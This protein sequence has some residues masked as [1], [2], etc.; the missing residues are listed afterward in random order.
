[1]KNKVFKR[2]SPAGILLA[3][4]CLLLIGA[5]V[6]TAT[7]QTLSA[8]NISAL[9][10]KP[11]SF[12][13][14][15]RPIAEVLELLS[16]QTDL[17]FAY[18]VS[19]GKEKLLVNIDVTHEKLSS[20]IRKILNPHQLDYSIIDGVA[21]VHNLKTTSQEKSEDINSVITGKVFDYKTKETLPG[22]IVSLEG[23]TQKLSTNNKGEFNFA[24]NLKAPYRLTVSYMGYKTTTVV[25]NN[26]PAEIYLQEAS[27]QLN[28]VVVVG[29]GTARKRDV[30][31][32]ITQIKGED[33]ND[34]PLSNIL[35]GMQGKAPGVDITSSLRP[36]G[37][38]EIRIRGNRS[39]NASNEPLYVVDG[40]PIS[41]NEA[42]VINSKDIASI[43]ILKDASATAIYGSRGANGVVLITLT[44]G[45]KGQVTINA[46]G[47]TSL[48]QIHSTTNWM[49]S[50]DLLQ[51]QR[52]AYINGGTY[53]GKYGTAPD[54]DFDVLT[55]GGG[56][57][58]GIRSIRN[59]YQW[60]ASGNVVLRDATPEEIASGYAARVPVYQPQNLL[61]QNW[62]DLVTRT[63][64]TN[65]YSLSLSSG[66]EKSSIYFSGG[67]LKQKGAMIDQDYKRY[68]VT[69]KGDVSPRNWLKLG[70]AT[71]G[72][73][74]VQNYGMAE[75]RSNT[76]GKDSYS[77]ALALMPYAPA[78]ND[79]GGLLNTNRSGLSA[80]NILLN[81]EN[82]KNEH[83]QYT[84]LS[85]S[86]AEVKFSPW[87]KY[88]VKFGAQFTQ[89]DYGSFY[90]SNYTNPFSAVGTAP[91]IGYNSQSKRLSWVVENLLTFNKRIGAHDLQLNLLQSQQENKTNGINIRAQGVTFPSSL[92]YNLSAN[93]LGEPM[94]YGTS[95]SRFSLL[96]YMGRLNYSLKNRYLIT[97][98]GRWDGASVLADGHKFDFF[99][100]LALAWK[101][102][103]EDLFKSMDWVN[104]LKL[105]YGWGRTGNSSVSPYS[106]SG[107]IGAAAYV[108]DE[109]QY[110]GYKSSSMPNV[111]LGWEKTAQHNV[112]LD[113]AVLNNR[114][115]GT[116]EL[117]KANTSDLL[118]SRSIPPVLGYNSILANIGK[119][120]NKGIE[121]A[122]SGQIVKGKHF[123]WNTDLTWSSNR[124]K[125]V[126]LT[127]GKVDDTA[128]GWYIGQPISVFRDYQFERLWQTEDTRLIELYKKIGNIT[129]LPGQVK[130]K[131]QQLVEVAPGTQGAKS[132]TLSSGEVVTYLDNGFGT[133]NDNDRYILGNNRPK[134]TGGLV[135]SFNYKSWDLS[136]FLYARVGNLYYGALQT[137]GRRVENDTWSPSNPGAAYP[138]PTTATFTNYNS[139]RNY[140]S[141]SMVALRYISLGYTFN[142]R[143]LTDWKVGKLQIYGQILN[144]FIWGG[145]AVQVGLNPDDTDGWESATAAASGGQTSNTI[146]LK[147]A[148]FGLRLGF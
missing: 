139:A 20:V 102:E 105:R 72:N 92:W 15:N 19:K 100:S 55:F 79:Q 130:I 146:L 49:N 141:G 99:P 113:F 51:W 53:T 7:S 52:Q 85:N 14:K 97:A 25:I 48:D 1:M 67:L 101:L 86:F 10:D 60:D 124:E 35:Q 58:Y 131:D 30:T 18:Q 6:T 26:S 46:D 126:E 12:K 143:L 45:K 142:Q 114:I 77:Q 148:V 32:A 75:N 17:R 89:T 134:W 88:H 54:P 127:D 44:S 133:I 96:S 66:T 95:F 87:L 78:Y 135:N 62:T 24:T 121:V 29:Y 27:N 145:K 125:I 69:L 93:N 38:G 22:A 122:L 138:Q 90:G 39:I 137:Y 68:T 16:R 111:G 116:I 64:I 81:I 106:T 41:A 129:A 108:F 28:E 80:H 21:V 5:S 128:N 119:T 43:E 109:T 140:V 70:T 120:S 40:I 104:Q 73:Y 42:S 147:S 65:N 117:Y 31:G 34:R 11:I 123:S 107:T 9:L 23:T 132:V 33:L 13:T 57:E 4:T 71:N 91:L 37:I 3:L 112:G 115:S 118:L 50:A 47:S 74:S 110:P 59:A 136:F 98:T 84:V 94:S 144:P 56:E 82:A 103:E 36:G 2:I 83:L 63:A 8:Q 61:N 76:G